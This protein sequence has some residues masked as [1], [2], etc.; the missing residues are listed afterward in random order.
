MKR[1]DFIP[2]P[3][4]RELAEDEMVLRA[5][6]FVAEL[7][8]RRTVRHFSDR[9]VPEEVLRDCVAAAASA[10]SGA[11]RQPWHFVIISDPKIKKKIREAAEEEE[12][13]FYHGR[14]PDDW[15]EA[16]AP[17]GTDE[18]KPFLE[19]A[20]YVIAVFAERYGIDEEGNKLK[21]YDVSES[22]GIAVGFLITAIHHAGLV[23]LTH[24]PAP[25]RFLAEILGRP[26]NE[27]PFLILPVGY[28]SEEATVP[29][30]DKKPL[31]QIATFLRKR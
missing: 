22:V 23:S 20:P 13:D 7:R 5:A 17:L 11:N 8:T 21:N 16:L 18:H 27:R 28:P 30:I 31:E 2:L 14:A 9:P 19:T 4:Y 12:R 25:M 3:D 26:G 15:L 29:N 1:T 6:D 24:T 10:P